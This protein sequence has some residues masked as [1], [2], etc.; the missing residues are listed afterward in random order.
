MGCHLWGRTELDMTEVTEQ[1]QQQYS[2]IFMYHIFFIGMQH[3]IG[4]ELSH[5]AYTEILKVVTDT[6]PIVL[7]QLPIMP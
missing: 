6:S 3:L 1:Q 7:L 5:A 4:I 2:I